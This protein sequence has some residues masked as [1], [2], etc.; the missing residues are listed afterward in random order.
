MDPAADTPVGADPLSRR[1]AWSVQASPEQLLEPDDAVTLIT[2]SRRYQVAASDLK[3]GMFVSELDRPWL[4]TPFLLQG[5]LADSQVEIDTLRKYCAYVYVDLEQSS[6]D[7]ADVIRR[8][9]VHTDTPPPPDRRSQRAPAPRPAATEP[10][11]AGKGRAPP[12]AVGQAPA[13]ER[14]KSAPRVYKTRADVRISSDTRNRFRAFVRATATGRSR[15]DAADSGVVGRAMAWL[16][17]RFAA[18]APTPKRRSSPAGDPASRDSVK[19]WL[20]PD[21]KLTTYTDTHS[22]EQELPRARS[23]FGRSEDV[24]KAVASDIKVGKIP[25][26]AEVSSAVDDMVDSMIDNPDALMWVGR[27]R[28]E[29]VNTYNHGVKVALYLIA[30][31]RQLGLPK[32]DLSHLGLIGMLADVGKIKLPRALLDK[33]GML[34]PSEY[35][36][37]KEHV[38]LGLEVIRTSGTIPPEVELGIAQHH[39][40]LDGSGYPNA[41][42][43]NDISIYGRMAAIADSFA[44]LITP[45]AYANASAP[46]DALMNLYEWAG[47]SF[48]EPLVEQFVQAVGVFPVGSLVEL[49]SG[50]I[51]VV[52]AHNRVRRLEPRV[53]V[54]TWPD[55]SSLATPIERDLLTQAKSSNGRL[56]IIRG[57]PAGAYGLRMRDYFM[58]EIARANALPG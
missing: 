36:L 25:Q 11:S 54:L 44:A 18:P 52:V 34:A 41:L 7:V 45:R 12:V 8:S 15:D 9:E 31:G 55:K 58:G 28:D 4:D 38:R 48:H 10:S 39:E 19:A 1:S 16:R 5:F 40:R 42:K 47:T 46:Q 33:P 29:D 27:L 20:P 30:L 56:R 21:I 13:P 49:S 50:E 6:P 2:A 32:K 43:G 53:L 51:A 57:L 37:I 14:R 22:V 24:L 17:G 3:L 23:T 35:G 26:V